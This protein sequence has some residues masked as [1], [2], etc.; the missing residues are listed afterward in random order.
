MR[1]T[2]EDF[3]SFDG[4]VIINADKLK[5]YTVKGVSID[6]RKCLN[7]DVFFAIKGE[8]FDG[9]NF[10]SDVVK[11][12]VKAVV[13]NKNNTTSVKRKLG[14]KFGSVCWIL[15]NDTLKSF[16]KLA[17]LYRSRF[18]IPVVAIGGSNGKTSVKDFTAFVLSKKYSVLK[19]ECNFNNRIGVPLTLFKLRK[20][21][22]IAVIEV[23]TNQFGEIE[24]LCRIA[25][26]QFGLLTNIGREHLEF[27]KNLK[28]VCKEEGRLID[29][30][31]NVY[32]T[33]FLNSDDKYIRKMSQ[34]RKLNIYSFGTH[35]NANVTGVLKRFKSFY[36]EIAISCGKQSFTTSLCIAGIQS[37]YSALAAS[38]VGLF[39]N[40]PFYHVKS[41]LHEIKRITKR[42]NE[43][44]KSKGYWIIDD[45]YNANPDSVK[46]ALQNLKIYKC[47]GKKHV[48]LGD[49]LEL[50]KTGI[51]E[52]CNAGRLVKQMKFDAL[53][54][55]GKLSYETYRGAKGLSS[56]YYFE[57]KKTL[58]EMLKL[59]ISKNDIVLVKGSRGMKM[60]EIVDSII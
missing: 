27:L 39:F 33:F 50:G 11:R 17:S 19:S 13:I 3:M 34:N 44:K 42:R 8:K 49:M 14:Y 24:E 58:I 46:A 2:L 36:P 45:S 20:K 40:V 30:L 57:D 51:A 5:S 12:G 41:A 60:E 21:H 29:Y 59:N 32:G 38:A 53:Y 47:S 56:N 31:E 35:A 25:K 43:I 6:S 15:V 26:P 18:L 4:A 1:F 9:H 10:I 23:G 22:N 55:Y 54:T 37:F 16:G 28:G 48:V 52:H 7:S